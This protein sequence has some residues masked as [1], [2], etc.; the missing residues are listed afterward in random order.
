MNEK[1]PGDGAVTGP[2]SIETY[3]EFLAAKA[4]LAAASGLNVDPAEV[5]PALKPHQRDAVV[6][7]VRGGRRAVFAA[8]GL[9]KTLMQLEVVRLV[10]AKL[11][12]GRG[13]IV[14][15]LGSARSSCATPACSTWR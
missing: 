2:P 12:R 9:G 14:L 8:F 6:W 13:L 15:P 1:A 4:S 11:G 5:D 7:A 10:L 3:R